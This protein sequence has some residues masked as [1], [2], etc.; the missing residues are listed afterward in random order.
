[1]NQNPAYGLAHEIAL[2][3]AYAKKH[4]ADTNDSAQT[5]TAAAPSP[6]KSHTQKQLAFQDIQSLP[7]DVIEKI[8]ENRTSVNY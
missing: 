2:K 3:E 4:A 6:L 1:M 8:T 5:A 7:D